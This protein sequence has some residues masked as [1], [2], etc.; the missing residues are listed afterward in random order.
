MVKTA[1]KN[2][3]I[4]QTQRIIA[5]SL[6]SVAIDVAGKT[7]KMIVETPSNVKFYLIIS[8]FSSK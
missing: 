7:N 1:I 3:P 8:V 6:R 5:R 4:S 2:V